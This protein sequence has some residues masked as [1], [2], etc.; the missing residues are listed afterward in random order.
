MR[1]QNVHNPTGD[2][3]QMVERSLSMREVRGSIPRISIAGFFPILHKFPNPCALENRW[4]VFAT[5]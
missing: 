3:A 2:V 1:S 5:F 4:E